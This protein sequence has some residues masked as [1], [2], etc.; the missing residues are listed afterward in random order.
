MSSDELTCGAREAI[1][2]VAPE[3]V[4]LRLGNPGSSLVATKRRQSSKRPSHAIGAPSSAE[5]AAKPGHVRGPLVWP[6][7]EG[8]EEA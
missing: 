6:D 2:K 1:L 4:L 5:P 8:D 7:A 3:T